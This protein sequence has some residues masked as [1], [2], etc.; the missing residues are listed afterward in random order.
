MA[1]LWLGSPLIYRNTL[2]N[3]M[4]KQRRTPRRLACHVVAETGPAEAVVVRRSGNYRPSLWDENYIQ[5]L[6]NKYAKESKVQ[7]KANLLKQEVK[8]R[9]DETEGPLQQLELIDTLQRL[10]LSY[11]F[12]NEITTILTKIHEG[13][14]NNAVTS[15]K[16]EDLNATALEFRLLRQ[17]GFFVSQD[18]FDDV[19]DEKSYE[20]CLKGSDN[21]AKSLLSL[22]EASY[23]STESDFKL[24]EIRSYAKKRLRDFV[25][26][27]NTSDQTE[28]YIREMIILSLEMPYHWRP[29]ALEARWYID[30]Y[31]KRRDMDPLLLEFAKLDFNIVQSFYQEDL[32][33][34]FRWWSKT[35][36]KELEFA[37]D[38]ILENYIWKVELFHEP[39]LGYQRREVTKTIALTTT[40]DDIY[41]VY[42]TMEELELFTEAVRRWDVNLVD[43]LPE[44]MRVCFLV[45][46]NEV[47]QTGHDILRDKK[48]N[49]IP[50]LRKAWTDIT[51]AYMVE[52]KWHKRGYKPTFKEYIENARIS[53]GAP[54]ILIHS[55]CV[56]ADKISKE[57][58]ESLVED[59]QPV[60]KGSAII[61]RVANDIGTSAD[62]LAR[63]DVQKSMQCHMHETGA[64]DVA[65]HD[66]MM[67][68]I[69]DAWDEMNHERMSRGSSL[70]RRFLQTSVNLGRMSLCMYQYGDGH[71]FPENAKTVD[72]TKSLI[73]DPIPLD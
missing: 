63:G 9:L 68:V 26:K 17:H 48:F 61:M 35:G 44:Y 49:V 13:R 25:T 52:A 70:H 30:V 66:Y 39:Q 29:V 23:L 3:S 8:K 60:V 12:D 51:S 11:H 6:E 58:I 47:N 72:R 2:P 71:G 19:K 27:S 64:S 32:K 4:Q 54:V 14:T 56:L 36:L 20:T 7:V 43:E 31:G 50:Y 18:V 55:Y 65:A 21:D 69:S 34:A 33:S 57:T 22:Y 24:K 1:S 16:I 53:I 10:G 62:E 59:R 41:D 15:H 42:G 37:R 5:S 67:D 45:L 73:L 40:I 46:F 38:R 28:S